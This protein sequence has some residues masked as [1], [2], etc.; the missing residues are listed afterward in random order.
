MATSP[1]LALPSGERAKPRNLLTVGVLM[2]G[3][4]GLV[5]VAALIAAFWNVGNVTHPWPPNGVKIENYPGTMLSLTMLMS[6]ATVE[7]GVW[8]VRR[9]QRGQAGGALG[10]TVGLG[11]AFLNLLWFFGKGIGFGPGKSAYAVI[12][13]SMLAVAGIL[14]AIGVLLVGGAAIR[15]LGRQ[16]DGIDIDGLRAT[17][18]FWEFAVVAWIAIYATIWLQ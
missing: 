3:A 1:M 15:V 8:G 9:Q 10:L 12:F 17:A 11:L 2:A 7:W 4:G 6:V 18:W 16:Y 5:G 14:V 13:F